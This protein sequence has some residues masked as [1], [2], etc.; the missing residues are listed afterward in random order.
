MPNRPAAPAPAAVAKKSSTVR[1]V[2]AAT[3]GHGM[4]NYS[5]TVYALMA[6][7]IARKYFPAEDPALS[8]LLTVATF[9][10]SFLIRPLGAV[11]LGVYADRKGR[12][13]SLTLSIK[14]MFIGSILMAFMPTYQ[15]IGVLAPIGM[16]VA[17]LVK[18]F[19]YSG[20]FAGAVSYL[21]EQNP[22]RRGFYGSWIITGQSLASIL[23]AVVL[24]ALTVALPTSVFESWAWRLP[25]TLGL[26]VGPIGLYLRRKL[27][28]SPE[29]HAARAEQG[30]DRPNPLGEVLRTQKMRML[31]V[32]GL[33]A[34]SSSASYLVTYMPTIG[35]R[36]LG[37]PASATFIAAL[38]GY[39]T[40]AIFDPIAGHLSDRYGRVRVM[41]IGSVGTAVT[42]LPLFLVLT[43]RR[44]M[45]VMVVVM[46]LIAF[47]KVWY[48]APNTAF[49]AEIFPIHTRGTGLAIGYN[50][51]LTIVGGCTPVIA[52]WL[53]QVTG[54]PIAPSFWL[55]GTAII[56]TA[57][58]FCATRYSRRSTGA[59]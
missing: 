5:F 29:F 11:V 58:V 33:V 9:A 28:D 26:F 14:L 43:S 22:K 21:I 32:V 47:V 17:L 45:L 50:V 35:V 31:L 56:S 15:T 30:A 19:S 12:I 3:I 44:T 52:T 53:I 24:T 55:I 8:L 34:L 37:L 27:H 4:E 46:A 2:I 39:A 23:A 10:G 6:D 40:S 25:F 48:V 57:S 59:Q 16:F 38:V 13:P 7:L 20:E 42:I 18:G 1:N 49:K 36:Q 51:G 54:S 41:T